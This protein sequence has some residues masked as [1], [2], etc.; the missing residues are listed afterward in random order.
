MDNHL[1]LHPL[2]WSEYYRNATI[3]TLLFDYKWMHR[4]SPALKFSLLRAILSQ[5]SK[6]DLCCPLSESMHVLFETPASPSSI[7]LCV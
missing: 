4:Y 3:S 1:L 2:H 5:V 7:A 6:V